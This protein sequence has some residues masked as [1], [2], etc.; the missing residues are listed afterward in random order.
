MS[1]GDLPA[2][3][4]W[5]IWWIFLLLAI[6]IL[7]PPLVGAVAGWRTIWLTGMFGFGIGIAVGVLGLASYLAWYIWVRDQLPSDRHDM[8]EAFLGLGILAALQ[9]LTVLAIIWC[10]ERRRNRGWP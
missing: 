10:I 3:E 5:F 9:S 1:Q 6:P 4:T 2:I 7:L 8:V